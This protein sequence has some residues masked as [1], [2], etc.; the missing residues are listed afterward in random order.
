MSSII[1]ALKK[2]DN[3]RANESGANLNQVK[4][5]NESPPKSRRGFW[6]LVLVLLLITLGTF[7]WTQG[8]H[9]NTL[10][11]IESWFGPTTIQAESE[12]ITNNKAQTSPQKENEQINKL[13]PPKM[14]DIKAKSM[15]VDKTKT[16][17]NNQ[18]QQ[19]LE[20]ITNRSPDSKPEHLDESLTDV[21]IEDKPMSMS[22]DNSSR[23]ADVMDAREKAELIAKQSRKDLEPKLKQ[24]YLLLH[25]ID[26]ELRKN[27]PA[28]KLNIHIYDPNPENRMVLLNGVKYVAGDLIEELV[29]VEEINQ[30]GVILKFEGTRFLIPK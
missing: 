19:Q 20:V 18:R 4:F 25:Q 1:D 13:T 28:I 9:Q 16:E 3:N 22:N 7:A 5:S 10:A 8:W 6:L 15:A 12:P 26:F 24:D 30:E 27:I 29:S 17:K 11:K 2:S 21:T 14:D 23:L